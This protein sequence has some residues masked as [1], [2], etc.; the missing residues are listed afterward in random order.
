MDF[1]PLSSQAGKQVTQ[2]GQLG[3]Y[4]LYS[5]AH[6]LLN[7]IL[8]NLKIIE[9][10]LKKDK[11]SFSSNYQHHQISAN[12]IKLYHR[13]LINITLIK[14]NGITKCWLVVQ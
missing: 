13:S 11:N 3:R 6:K 8:L 2:E 7:H 14:K 5:L 9:H 4:G 10:I 1:S 12:I